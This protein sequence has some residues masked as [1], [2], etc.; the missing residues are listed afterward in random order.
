[1]NYKKIIKK[2]RKLLI[3]IGNMIYQHKN[4]IPA[5]QRNFINDM[6][7]LQYMHQNYINNI[8]PYN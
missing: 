6:N 8:Y 7:N 3:R 1:M 4:Q 2:I 5:N